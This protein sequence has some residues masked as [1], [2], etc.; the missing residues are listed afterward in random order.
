MEGMN[1]A[2]LIRPNQVTMAGW[3]VMVGSVIVVITVFDQL[4]SLRSVEMREAVQ[5]FL[6]EPPGEGLG[7]SVDGTLSIIKALSLVAAGCATAAAILGWHILRRDKGARLALSLLA[8]PLFLTG[9]VAGGFFSA[10]VAASAL[11]LWTQPARDWFN[12][13]SRSRPAADA[14]GSATQAPPTHAPPTHAPPTHAPPTHAPPTHAPPTHAPP[15]HAP[16]THAPPTQAPPAGPPAG[17]AA[18]PPAPGVQ[19]APYQHFGTAPTVPTSPP[20]PP[21]RRPDSVVWATV[22]TW[23]FSGL[24]LIVL[25]ASAF[26]FAQ[27]P[28]GLIAE[29][30]QQQ[31]SFDDAGV[32]DS[33]LIAFASVTM[34]IFAVWALVA[35]LL[36]LFVWRGRDWARIAL[37]VSA[38]VAAVVSI[39]GVV[40]GGITLPLLVACGVVARLLLAPPAATWCRRRRVMD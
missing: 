24:T 16:P 28:H 25:A 15:T 33:M 37:V 5:K 2:K 20:A 7:L 31:P 26:V 9:I 38:L 22:L 14:T 3:M 27:D 12:G 29:A 30:R 6:S 13:V 19:P 18:G 4:G 1:D 23:I 36:A 17:P 39:I 40:A 10:L 34:A 11:M 35:A 32:S 8:V 21:L